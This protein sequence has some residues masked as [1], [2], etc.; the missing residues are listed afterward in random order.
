VFDIRCDNS[1]PHLEVGHLHESGARINEK[2]FGSKSLQKKV[3]LFKTK[4]VKS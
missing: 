4:P 3:I 2:M 1:H